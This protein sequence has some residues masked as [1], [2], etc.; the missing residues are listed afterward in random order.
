VDIRFAAL[1]VVVRPPP[2]DAPSPRTSR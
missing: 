1:Q 2:S